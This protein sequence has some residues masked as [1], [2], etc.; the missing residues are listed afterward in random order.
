MINED[1]RFALRCRCALRG[2]SPERDVVGVA[3]GTRRSRETTGEGGGGSKGG[4]AGGKST[5]CESKAYKRCMQCD[6]QRDLEP[7]HNNA[8]A[9]ARHVQP[10]A[11]RLARLGPP[12]KRFQETIVT[13]TRGPPAVAAQRLTDDRLK[14]DLPPAPWFGMP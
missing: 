6:R 7:E 12:A 1:G 10:P 8:A 2:R 14:T 4:E 11:L 13:Q 5:T 3:R 9:A